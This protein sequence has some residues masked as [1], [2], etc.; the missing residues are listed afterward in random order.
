MDSS[1]C[2]LCGN[3][4]AIHW[5]DSCSTLLC[6]NEICLNQHQ[7]HVIALLEDE[8]EEEIA[9]E[10]AFQLY[11]NLETNAHILCRKLFL[12]SPP[13]NGNILNLNDWHTFQENSYVLLPNFIPQDIALQAREYTLK[14]K[15]QNLL[16]DYSH[17]KDDNRDQTARKDLRMFLK[18]NHHVATNS[19][20]TPIIQKLIELENELKMGIQLT[21][22][23]SEMQLA[24]YGCN[25]ENYTK[26]RDGFPND[27]SLHLTQQP[28]RRVTATVY[29]NE[30]KE[31]DGGCLRLYIP[32]EKCDHFTTKDVPPMAGL[33]VLF[34]S[35][36]MDHEVLPSYSDRTAIA[37][38]YC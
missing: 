9:E 10:D 33:C 11:E 24:Y 5:C 22:E 38:W 14:L 26:H 30:H 6:S 32:N 19:P 17:L 3:G 13:T 2:D 27:G 8:I 18:P 4:V 23:Q 1:L 15:D 16:T 37:A 31:E 21:G 34:L 12:P 36:A 25:G 7:N 28:G 35:G 20:L 29:M